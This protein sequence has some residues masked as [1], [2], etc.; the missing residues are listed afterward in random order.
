MLQLRAAAVCTP[1][2]RGRRRRQRGSVQFCARMDP[3]SI[4]SLWYAEY[5]P[6]TGTLAYAGA[7]HP[8]PVLA[9]ADGST[10]LLH[11]S[12]APPLG[13]GADGSDVAV[14]VDELPPGAVWWPG[15]WSHRT[16]RRRLKLQIAVLQEVVAAACHPMRLSGVSDIAGR[17]LETLIPAPG[18]AETT[19]ACSSLRRELD[20]VI[21]I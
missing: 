5:Q 3:E 15:G 14:H 9:F 18:A 19:S 1:S 13:A 17:I 20:R 11:A 6:S 16:P 10:R 21:Q 4:A 8:P 2:N 12:D 7:G